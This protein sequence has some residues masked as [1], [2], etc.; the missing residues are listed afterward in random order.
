MGVRVEQQ[1]RRIEALLLEAV[2]TQLVPDAV[3]QAV[4]DV[5]VQLVSVANDPCCK[6]LPAAKPLLLQS[7]CC[8]VAPAAAKRARTEVNWACTDASPFC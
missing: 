2:A 5:V 8:C 6:A 3:T 4:N 7:P 1:R